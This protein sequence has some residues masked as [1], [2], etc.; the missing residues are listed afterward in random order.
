MAA[1]ECLRMA[2]ALGLAT[3]LVLLGGAYIGQYA[4]G[5]FPCEMCWWQRYAHFA[6]LLFAVL[7]FAVPRR[8]APVAL[9]AVAIGVSAVIGAYHAGV[10][11]QWWQGLTACTS[12]AATGGNP[13][14]AIMHAP[15]VRCDVAQWTL[16]GIS[17]AGWNFLISSSAAL[18]IAVLLAHRPRV[19]VA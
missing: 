19:A 5:L 12:T 6:A 11:Y 8:R 7:A 10:E 3:P 1:N 14:D 2:R 4:F 13:L 17:L 18:S 16:F 9:A 15:L